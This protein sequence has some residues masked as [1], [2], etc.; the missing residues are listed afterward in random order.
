MAVPQDP[1]LSLFCPTVF[2]EIAYGPR[3]LRLDAATV[4][5]RVSEHASALTLHELLDRAP[6]ALS[7][8]QRL[9][10]AVAAALSC[11]PDLLLLDEPTAGQDGAQVE[12][13]LLALSA[14]SAPSLL[15]ATHD[16]DL[17]LRH[18]TRAVVL[19]DGKLVA[20]GDPATV[21]A[22]LPA[23]SRIVIPPIHRFAMERGFRPGSA[24][25]LMTQVVGRA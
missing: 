14:P 4:D 13:L 22:A 16:V 20:D 6:Q 11:G 2:D 25:A 7:R 24:S 17:V 8:G 23:D 21:L 1:D 19:V 15:F 9:R 12:A 10:T 5:R 18:A 3:E